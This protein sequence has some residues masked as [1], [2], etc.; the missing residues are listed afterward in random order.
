[1]KTE[2]II[3]LLLAALAV[4]Y[5][6]KNALAQSTSTSQTQLAPSPQ[7]SQSANIA[8][9]GNTTNG[10][11]DASNY[12]NPFSFFKSHGS[13]AIG[14]GI[15]TP[16]LVVSGPMG[17]GPASY[18]PANAISN[19]NQKIPFRTPNPRAVQV[20]RIRAANVKLNPSTYA[21]SA[22]VQGSIKAV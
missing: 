1:M 14:T 9:T 2:S 10:I 21:K 18:S 16:T 11:P 17:T 7:P 15:P 12:T 19:R 4:W 13:G 3:A 6:R 8:S 20:A 22:G 5:A